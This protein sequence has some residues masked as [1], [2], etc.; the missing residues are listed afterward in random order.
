ME[1]VEGV[2]LSM[3]CVCV[4]HELCNPEKQLKLPGSRSIR[5]NTHTHTHTH[6]HC[7]RRTHDPNGFR[8]QKGRT[9]D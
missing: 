6:T 1:E 8:L 7:S 2:T 5:T 3:V 4:S 9:F